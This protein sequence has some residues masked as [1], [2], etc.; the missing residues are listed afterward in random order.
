MSSDY[1]RWVQAVFHLSSL[2]YASIT[3]SEIELQLLSKDSSK[4]DNRVI[5]PATESEIDMSEGIMEMFGM[6]NSNNE[7]KIYI[8]FFFILSCHWHFP[9]SK[10][11]TARSHF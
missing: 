2:S 3:Q 7:V 1:R 6:S 10:Y 8:K 4:C 9:F 5:E 11:G